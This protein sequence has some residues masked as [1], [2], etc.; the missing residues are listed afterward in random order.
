MASFNTNA[1]LDAMLQYGDPTKYQEFLDFWKQGEDYK[2]NLWKQGEDYNLDNDQKYLGGS[3][4][5][6]G[7]RDLEYKRN[8]KAAT[9]L[10]NSGQYAGYKS[11][12]GSSNRYDG[13]S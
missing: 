13:Y 12:G 6:Y 11:S 4:N 9:D 2:F 3:G 7:N 1:S 5:I 10:A 8:K